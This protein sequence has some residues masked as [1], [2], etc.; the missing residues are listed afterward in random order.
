MNSSISNR[1]LELLVFLVGM[2]LKGFD[3]PDVN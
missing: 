1:A 2:A 3:P